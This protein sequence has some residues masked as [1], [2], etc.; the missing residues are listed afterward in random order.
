[1]KTPEARKSTNIMWGGNY[2]E[3]FDKLS[4]RMD[5]TKVTLAR[6]LMDRLERMDEDEIRKFLE[7]DQPGPKFSSIDPNREPVVAAAHTLFHRLIDS[8]PEHARKIAWD[9][10][11]EYEK[12]NTVSE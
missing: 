12:A 7:G 1:M 3:K 4:K 10:L 9:I 2:V 8:N 6:L 11:H 5:L